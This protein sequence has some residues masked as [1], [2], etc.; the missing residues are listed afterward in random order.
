MMS[1]FQNEY[2][3]SEKVVFGVRYSIVRSHGVMDRVLASR[4]KGP[5][6]RIPLWLLHF[7]GPRFESRS[8]FKEKSRFIT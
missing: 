4:S 5:R 3:F 1:L 6:F 7:G 2:C 8:S